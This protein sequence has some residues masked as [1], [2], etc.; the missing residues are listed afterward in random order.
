[1]SSVTSG[2]FFWGMM[3]E[4]VVKASSSSTKRNSQL[5][6]RMTSSDRRE[7]CIMQVA[8]AAQS[9]MQKSRSETPSMELWQGAAKPS[10]LAV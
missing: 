1:M 8:M 10:S 2:F 4:P 5:H 9:S 6:Q 7:R 3:E